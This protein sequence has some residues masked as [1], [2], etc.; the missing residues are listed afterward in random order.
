MVPG[1]P[2]VNGVAVVQVYVE[3]TGKFVQDRAPTPIPPEEAGDAPEIH[4]K[5]EAVQVCEKFYF[6]CK[7]QVIRVTFSF[8]LSHNIVYCKLKIVVACITTTQQ[9]SVLQVEKKLLQKVELLSTLC[10]IL[11]QFAIMEFVAWQ[12]EHAV[13]IRATIRATTRSTCNATML[14]HKLNENVA[15]ITWP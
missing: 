14:R 6:P 13:V 2:G 10:N 8:N 7:G 5:K 3:E 9:I 12:V 11:S 1:L 15:R 4:L